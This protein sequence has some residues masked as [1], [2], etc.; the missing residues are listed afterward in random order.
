MGMGGYGHLGIS[1][2]LI[3]SCPRVSITAVEKLISAG[4]GL[5]ELRFL[6]AT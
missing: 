3:A 6:T 4:A 5:K 1:R 2:K